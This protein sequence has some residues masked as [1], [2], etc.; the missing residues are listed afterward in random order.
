MQALRTHGDTSA[1]VAEEACAL[2]SNLVTAQRHARL[3]AE[4][5][6]EALMDAASARHPGKEGVQQQVDLVRTMLRDAA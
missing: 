5:G 3:A 1:Q 4:L 2:L 6:V